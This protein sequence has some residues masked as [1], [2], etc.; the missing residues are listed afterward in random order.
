MS[1]PTVQDVDLT[2]RASFATWISDNV[3]FGDTDRVGHVNN[4]VFA[5][6]FETGRV[7]FLY[8]PGQPLAPPGTDFVIVR[9]EIDFR[10]E[11]HYPGTVDIGTRVFAISRRSFTMGQGLFHEGKCSATAKSVL[12]LI[13]RETRKA[14][15]FPD[16]LRER[17][18]AYRA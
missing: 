8:R 9:L 15:V 17:L 5:T 18:E 7:A 4:A 10:A 14:V 3:R 16:E 2:D 12:V 11:M 13:D 6:M 1:E